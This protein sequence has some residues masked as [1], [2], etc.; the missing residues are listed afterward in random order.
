MC[1]MQR[2][3]FLPHLLFCLL[4]Q[5]GLLR[6]LLLIFARHFLSRRE[7]ALRVFFDRAFLQARL[8]WRLWHRLFFLMSLPRE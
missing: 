8:R 3:Y 7:H 1:E 5:I 6:H 2:S 4:L